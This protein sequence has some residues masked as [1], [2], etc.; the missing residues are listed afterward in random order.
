MSALLYEKT[1]EN[2]YGVVPEVLRD[3]SHYDA[4]QLKLKG[5]KTQHVEETKKLFV[6]YN[7]KTPYED[8]SKL[9]EWIAYLNK[10]R[11]LTELQLKE[12]EGTVEV[13]D[14]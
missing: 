1:T 6:M 2:I 5:V 7:N 12:L 11:R 14:G 13:N 4:L 10:A 3:L 8:I 9:N